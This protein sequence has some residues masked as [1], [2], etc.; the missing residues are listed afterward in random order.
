MVYFR[1]ATPNRGQQLQLK[2]SNGNVLSTVNIPQTQ[3]FQNWTMVTSTVSLNAGQ[4]TIRV[5]SNQPGNWNINYLEFVNASSS[6][7]LPGYFTVPGRIEAENYS[8]MFGVMAE[9]TSDA[10]GGNNV[11]YIEYGDWMTYNVN[12]ANSANYLVKFRVATPFNGQQLQ[13]KNSSGNVLATLDIP[14]TGYFQNWTTV[15]V[16]LFLYAGNQTITVVSSRNGYFNINWMQFETG[17][18]LQGNAVE[19]GTLAATELVPLTEQSLSVYPNPVDKLF[20]MQIKNNHTGNM[21]VQVV[22]LAGIVVKQYKFA[23][24]SAVSQVNLSVGELPSGTYLIK[25]QIGKWT[26]TKKLFKK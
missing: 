2:G 26:E 18:I 9:N 3:G 10:G 23:K 8:S 21:N 25:L 17:T 13:V 24:E 20:T 19:S 4:Q 22:N 7:S 12:V 14:N 6:A 16:S 5:Y 15:S 11:G 1:V